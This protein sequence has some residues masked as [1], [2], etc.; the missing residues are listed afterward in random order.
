MTGTPAG[1]DRETWNRELAEVTELALPAENSPRSR[2]R[3]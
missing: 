2:Y 1:A 3:C